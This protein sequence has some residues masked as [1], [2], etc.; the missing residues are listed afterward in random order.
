MRLTRPAPADA[1]QW[2][3]QRC[4]PPVRSHLR[5]RF[6]PSSTAPL[7]PV[8]W[9]A[10]HP[11]YARAETG[12]RE[13]CWRHHRR[14]A[15]PFQPACNSW[16]IVCNRNCDHRSALGQGLECGVQPGMCDR[17]CGASQQFELRESPWL[18][19][20]RRNNS[21]TPHQACARLLATFR[22]LTATWRT[23]VFQQSPRTRSQPHHESR[24][25]LA[26]LSSGLCRALFDDSCPRG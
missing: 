5:E 9:L 12:N 10:E 25:E 4:W 15:Q 8:A 18:I 3:V 24:S 2:L 1:S 7:T 14:H 11:A 22:K 6:S 21:H 23:W 17:Q 20:T 16:L 26:R 19:P 13:T